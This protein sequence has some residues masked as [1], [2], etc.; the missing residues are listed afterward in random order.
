M[1]KPPCPIC[2]SKKWRKDASGFYVCQYGH[3]LKGYQEELG[4]D[5]AL[6]A[7]N[8]RVLKRK[9]KKRRKDRKDH[10]RAVFETSS[11]P[12]LTVAFEICQCI[13]KAQV[14][15]LISQKKFP[16]ELETAVL[17]LWLLYLE[18]RTMSFDD[19]EK[20]V[21]EEIEWQQS[22][23]ASG[24]SGDESE[25]SS[26]SGLSR[27][28]TGTAASSTAA[29]KEYER[30]PAGRSF[31]LVFC[32]LGCIMLRL[33]VV[34]AD[35][36]R[37]A[38]TGE[39]IYFDESPAIPETLYTDF[40]QVRKWC[41]Q[42][43]R[44]LPSVSD[45]G[46]ESHRMIHRLKKKYGLSFPAVNRPMFL[47]RMMNELLLPVE[48]YAFVCRLIQL[49]DGFKPALLFGPEERPQL[50]AYIIIALKLFY[51]LD[52][53][54]RAPPEF[55]DAWPVDE[56]L[57]TLTDRS[58]QPT[59]FATLKSDSVE[60]QSSD[61]LDG[62]IQFA[63]TLFAGQKQQKETN[64]K[65]YQAFH[66]NVHHTHA[67]ET[68]PDP[69]ANPPDTTSLRQQRLNLYNKTPNSSTSPPTDQQALPAPG[70]SY[71]IFSANDHHGAYPSALGT[72]IEKCCEIIGESTETLGKH[73]NIIEKKLRPDALWAARLTA[74]EVE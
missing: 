27:S 16:K 4:D 11:S 63:K 37:W 10:K 47:L 57:E 60:L 30:H 72:L 56:W 23:Q 49:V 32:Y 40:P 35:L 59:L 2:R 33:P 46:S 22:S 13:L 25:R 42:H 69:H 21:I 36:H 67:P 41:M 68:P 19:R 48:I 50:V 62:Y 38:A 65:G 7:M 28:S 58:K 54:L 26:G 5:E 53:K 55:G 1:K 15:W 64:V 31:T 74:E 18:T 70:S 3:Q 8:S 6:A 14:E 45:I 24:T 34:V 12:P 20:P 73:I 39:M 29:R 51:G 52:G 71:P 17:H 43:Q 61:D 9:R 44:Y 66:Q